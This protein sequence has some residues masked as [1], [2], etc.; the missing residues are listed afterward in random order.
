[1]C[2]TYLE[3]SLSGFNE[4]R[5]LRIAHSLKDR[6]EGGQPTGQ[7]F[8]F[9]QPCISEIFLIELPLSNSWNQN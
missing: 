6:E 4:A 8:H 9:G 2:K 5:R 1:M 3:F 7:N